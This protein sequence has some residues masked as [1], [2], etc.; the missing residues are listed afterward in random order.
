M[1][2]GSQLMY[3]L[4]KKAT[5]EKYDFQTTNGNKIAKKKS[6]RRNRVSYGVFIYICLQ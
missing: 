5:G 4:K 2:L 1:S 6:K 3:G